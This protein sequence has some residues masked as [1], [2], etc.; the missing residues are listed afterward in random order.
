MAASAVATHLDNMLPVASTPSERQ[1]RFDALVST[2]R[3]ALYRHA[4]WISG[5]HS[6]ADDLV[7]ET[8]L[9]AWRSLDRL[10]DPAAAKSWLI[11]ILRREN[12]RRFERFQPQQSAI[13]TEELAARKP[14]YDT[15]TEAFALRRALQQLTADY[16]E[17][18]L[19]QILHGYSQKE[20]AAHLGISPAGVGTRLFR[21]RQQLRELLTAE[22][23]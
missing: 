22:A 4:Y 3:Q 21:A 2:H 23:V 9:R 10:Q 1:L 19:L 17:P 8:F 13:P 12:A 6:V 7:Q 18:L 20:I 16:R 14:E 5:D 15:S 11:T